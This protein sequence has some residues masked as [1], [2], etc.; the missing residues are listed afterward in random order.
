M[1]Y[2]VSFR[3]RAAKEYLESVAWYKEKSQRAAE[4]FVLNMDIALAE[5]RKRPAQFRKS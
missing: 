3:K 5:I 1:A 2:T 4:N